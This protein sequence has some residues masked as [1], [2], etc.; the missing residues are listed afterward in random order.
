[1]SARR[2]PRLLVAAGVAVSVLASTGCSLVFGADPVFPSNRCNSGDVSSTQFKALGTLGGELT[3]SRPI[4][5]PT[6]PGT[7]Q[8]ASG[9]GMRWGTMH[10][11][12]D[13]AGP[14]GTPIYATLD[15]NVVKAGP[16]DGFGF[17]IVIDS[18]VNDRQVSTVYGHMYSDSIKVQV[19]QHVNVGDHIADIGNAGQSTGPHVHFEYYEGGTRI[20][21]GHSID[22]MIKLG[23]VMGPQVTS[24]ATV[25]TAQVQ[26][27]AATA[28]ANCNGFGTPGG[29]LVSGKVPP[30]LEPW[31]RKAG[32]LCPE[33]S[34]SLL[35][36]Q[37]QAESNFRTD[38]VSPDGAQGVA[39]FMPGTATAIAPDGQPY[40]IDADGNGKADPKDPADGIIGQGRY[41]CAIAKTIQGWISQGK[42]SGDLT[43]LTVAAYNAGEGAVLTSGGMPNQIPRHFTE[44]RPYVQKILAAEPGFRSQTGNGRFVADGSRSGT[45][46]VEAARQF[47]G[48]PYSWGGGGTGGPTDPGNGVKGFDC[49]GLT[50]YAV[51][52]ATGGALTLPRTSEE[53]WKVGT[54]VSLDQAQP[55]DLLFGSWGPGGPGHVGIFVSGGRMIH[56]PTTNESVT[57]AAVQP[58]MKA[59]RV[60]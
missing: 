17:W 39:Q 5:P 1:M 36:A 51:F 19:G 45:Q 13:F 57:E 47:L 38:A 23:P 7:T 14:I 9:Y 32:S 41:M 21:G 56:S 30:D 26:L 52:A 34:A 2:G 16:A 37:G 50:Q 18:L 43:A 29:G 3:N 49:S 25:S 55:G 59:R 28:P 22:P 35:A 58:G 46:V 48:T 54:E 24:T 40:V 11:G 31:Y 44:T 60:L 42:V 10:A 4:Q 20:N 33:I 15:G 53:Q 8:I 12:V 6:K 27:A